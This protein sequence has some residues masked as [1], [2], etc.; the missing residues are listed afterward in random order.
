MRVRRGGWVYPEYQKSLAWENPSE[1][2]HW[3]IPLLEASRVFPSHGGPPSKEE[4]VP[5]SSKAWSDETLERGLPRPF[6]KK[7]GKTGGK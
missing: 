7:K 6:A 5:H 4:L 2:L 3:P 1:R